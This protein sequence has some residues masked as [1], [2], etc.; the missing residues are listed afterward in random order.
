M[1][2]SVAGTCWT[3]WRVTAK[4]VVRKKGKI[5]AFRGSFK[6]LL[7]ENRHN[8]NFDKND[9]NFGNKL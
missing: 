3:C 7:G 1:E 4:K 6:L 5:P 2:M 8:N 9:I